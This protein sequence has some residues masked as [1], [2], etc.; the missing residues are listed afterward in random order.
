MDYVA[1]VLECAINDRGALDAVMG[2]LVVSTEANEPGTKVYEWNITEDG[3]TLI[4]YE[5]FAGS[6]AALAHH[7]GFGPYAER[8]LSAVTVTRFVVFGAVGEA[9]KEALSG[10]QPTYVSQIGGFHR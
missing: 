7:V 4:T 1:F 3:S 6:D 9:L 8:F 2:D 10:A 5:R